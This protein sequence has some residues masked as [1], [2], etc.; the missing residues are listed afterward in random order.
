MNTMGGKFFVSSVP[1]H[2]FGRFIDKRHSMG[3][4]MSARVMSFTVVVRRERN[5]KVQLRAEILRRIGVIIEQ[6]K[7]YVYTFV[8][9]FHYREH[10]D[11][12][13]VFSS[14]FDYTV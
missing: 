11:S 6:S 2:F 4:W 14:A 1:G 12:Y 3:N 9:L 5:Y 8:S 10:C 13:D 7:T